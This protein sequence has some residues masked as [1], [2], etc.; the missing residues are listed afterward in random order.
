MHSE[1]GPLF[2]HSPVP[3]WIY[4]VVGLRFLDV[5]QAA[6][7][8][9]GYTR[10]QFQQMTLADIRPADQRSHLEAALT[11]ASDAQH[12]S[13]PY[14]HK[15][16]SGADIYMR[17]VSSPLSYRGM[18]ARLVAAF[19]IA[20]PVD[21]DN[22]EINSAQARAA[23]LMIDND[24]AIRYA[25]L[26]A[27]ELL[28][29]TFRENSLGNLWETLAT[30][31]WYSL[32][33]KLRNVGSSGMP[34]RFVV[35]HPTLGSS[36]SVLTQTDGDALEITLIETTRGDLLEHLHD[37][38]ERFQVA[39]S[40]CSE[41]IWDYDVR[42]GTVWLGGAFSTTFGYSPAQRRITLQEWLA[43][44][45][46]ED[47]SVIGAQLRRVEARGEQCWNCSYRLRHADG[48][49]RTV[50]H[51]ARTI[52][53]V[54]GAISRVVGAVENVTGRLPH[55]GELTP[56]PA[57]FGAMPAAV[58]VFDVR[59]PRW[60]IVYVNPAL[61]SM[62][63]YRAKDYLGTDG[64]FAL[65]EDGNQPGL[66]AIADAVA[67]YLPVSTVLRCRRPDGVRYLNEL[68]LSPMHDESGTLAYYICIQ[69]NI[70]D[71]YRE[72]PN[73]QQAWSHDPVT[74]LPAHAAVE[75]ALA[76]LIAKAES[77]RE[78]LSLLQI[79][80]AGLRRIN[81]THGYACGD[82]V[83]RDAAATVRA[84]LRSG[85]ELFRLAGG[86]FL[87]IVPDDELTSRGQTLQE[88]V[89]RAIRLSV[90][91]SDQTLLLVA[92]C[93]MSCYPRH[94]NTAA[95]LLRLAA[96][97]LTAAK[98]N[99][100]PAASACM[101]VASAQEH[102][103]E[104]LDLACRL[105]EALENRTLQM[106]YQPQV[107]VLRRELVGIEALARWNDARYGA[108]PADRFVRIADSAGLGKSLFWWSLHSS[109]EQ[110]R[111]WNNAG[112]YHRTIAVN[113]SPRELLRPGFVRTVERALE[114]FDV[115]A[116]AL[117]LEVT[118]EL[119]IAANTDSVARLNSIRQ[120]G[121]SLVI[122][123][124]GK[125]YS[126]LGSLR[127]L[128]PSKLKVDRSFVEGLVSSEYDRAVVQ[129]ALSLARALDIKVVAEGV[130]SYDQAELLLSLGCSTMQGWL[131]CKADSPERIEQYISAHHG[132]ATGPD[133][134][135][136]VLPSRSELGS[137]ISAC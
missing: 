4:D 18:P 73:R 32:S 46:P 87:V 10:E 126:S 49:F 86:D 88:T 102:A 31:P 48:S 109:C 66:M 113:V 103:N 55:A 13:G 25:S 92:R 45:H 65:D 28:G 62:T 19:E 137:K 40:V 51:R 8:R 24:G 12:D 89:T 117:E 135:N 30:L 116:Q 1:F 20:D 43:L 99:G 106:H 14:R 5:N 96:C 29:L 17:I 64:A 54:G 59:G 107:D 70:S 27:R 2:E 3:M 79:D 134:S 75:P 78:A 131:F 11:W 136:T 100:I 35:R 130:S 98:Q 21:V 124:F 74:G 101:L 83:L 67:K 104:E 72:E 58:S 53:D 36:F 97:S 111:R 129:S 34:G 33:E 108:V 120:L 133:P 26:D 90:E 94:G 63:G 84:C 23:T 82:S 50:A 123:D 81:E 37:S 57:L 6:V 42:T 80:I 118:E 9:Y 128:R 95:D 71:H 125:G 119:A 69:T 47:T 56:W 105:H 110:I 115:P 122:D 114:L 93:G 22:R 85:E 121:V 127:V 76:A 44:L 132:A 41:L 77:K 68:R 7:R 91:G 38:M 112:V 15:T 60:T 52:S 39:A 61:E 16:C